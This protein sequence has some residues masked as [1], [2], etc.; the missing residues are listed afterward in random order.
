MPSKLPLL[1]PGTRFN[2]WTVL[3]F[4][5]RTIKS[6]PYYQCVC[7]CGNVG[8]VT[9]TQLVSG[10]S[11][12]CSCLQKEVVTKRNFKH[13]ES[14]DKTKEYTTWRGMMSRCYRKNDTRWLSYGGRGIRVCEQWH[15]YENFLV[16]MG[17]KPSAKHSIDRIDVNG[18]YEPS[19]C[20]WATDN[21]QRMN[22]R[23]SIKWI[24]QRGALKT[25]ADKY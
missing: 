25:S 17:R 21:E 9:R 19:N 6:V 15:R 18:N 12:S 4:S 7:Q 22:K 8:V 5:H 23:N 20:R 11:K 14:N 3:K 24:S 2:R 13:G 1:E 10:K 16:D